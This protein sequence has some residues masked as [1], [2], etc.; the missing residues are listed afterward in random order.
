[1]LCLS[2]TVK[3]SVLDIT[4]KNIDKRIDIDDI[5]VENNNDIFPAFSS[6]LA[7]HG[8][9]IL[10]NICPLAV[11]A[12]TK[13]ILQPLV[14]ALKRRYDHMTD[15]FIEHN[16]SLQGTY[17]QPSPYTSFI[18]FLLANAFLSISFHPSIH[19]MTWLII[20]WIGW[21]A[22]RTIATYRSRQTQRTFGSLREWRTSSSV[23]DDKCL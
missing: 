6:S 12:D 23:C 20:R 13:E 19:R 4:G 7:Q 1:M 17:F 14:T 5:I 11:V 9:V 22:Y 21:L 15:E 3:F 8:T 2:R 10:K 18:P 16:C